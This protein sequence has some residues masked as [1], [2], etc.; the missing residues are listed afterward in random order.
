PDERMRAILT[1]AAMVGDATARALTYRF[2]QPEGY[3]YPGS[4]WRLGVLGGYS[5]TEDGVL[6]LDS[7]A[8]LYFY[9]GATS[10][11]WEQKAVG[12]GSQYALAFVDATGVPFDGDRTYRLHVPPQVPVNNFW[13]VLVYDTQTRS[14]LQTDQQWP[15]VTSQ[16][17]DLTTNEDGSVDVR[18]GPARPGEGGNWVQTLP[19]KSWF[20]MFRLYGPLEPWFDKTWKLPE[21]EP[22]G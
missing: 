11:S 21:I 4:A 8:Q 18:F 6:L 7:A 16:D 13:S 22:A 12:T 1:E 5:C 9:V 2:R 10:P 19:G 3:Y 14:M 15:S 20:A 17:A